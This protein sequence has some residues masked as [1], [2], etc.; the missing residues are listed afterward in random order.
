MYIYKAKILFDSNRVLNRI[1]LFANFPRKAQTRY[2]PLSCVLISLQF[3]FG[4]GDALSLVE[5][6]WESNNDCCI[7]CICFHVIT[8]KSDRPWTQHQDLRGHIPCILVGTSKASQ[9]CGQIWEKLRYYRVPL[10]ENNLQAPIVTPN[11]L[12]E[13]FHGKYWPVL[14]V[15]MNGDWRKWRAGRK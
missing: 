7:P 3:I 10:T 11:Y 13:Y 2:Q 12:V 6:A 5:C 1:I 4:L 14:G 9:E 8:V 15:Q